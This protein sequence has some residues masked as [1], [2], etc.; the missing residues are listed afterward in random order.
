MMCLQSDAETYIVIV[1][2]CHAT[3]Q[4]LVK[5]YLNEPSAYL[6][7]IGSR[8]KVRQFRKGTDWN[9]AVPE[10]LL[11]RLHAPIGLPIGGKD[12]AEVAD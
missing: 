1:T 5:R 10:K 9:K 4:F 7:L 8:A 6:G 3:D 2:R 12:P 11:D